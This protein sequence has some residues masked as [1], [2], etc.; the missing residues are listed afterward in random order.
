[1]NSM[2]QACPQ[3][4]AKHEKKKPGIFKTKHRKSV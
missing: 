3:M 4:Q 2:G 1:M